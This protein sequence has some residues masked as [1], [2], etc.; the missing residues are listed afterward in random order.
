MPTIRTT[1]WC[2]EAIAILGRDGDSQARNTS[3]K[4]AGNATDPQRLAAI[5]SLKPELHPAERDGL[6][7]LLPSALP[8][9]R[10]AILKKLANCVDP[11]LPDLFL[12]LL[13]E[14]D[15]AQWGPAIKVLA[16]NATPK[17]V[18]ALLALLR[19][20]LAPGDPEKII[21]LNVFPMCTWDTMP[22]SMEDAVSPVEQCAIAL[23]QIGDPAVDPLMQMLHDPDP[24][25]RAAAAALL[26]LQPAARAVAPLTRALTD[27]DPSVREFA[28]YALRMR[29]DVDSLPALVAAVHDPETRVRVA[30]ALALA[31]T[32]DQR[33][34]P[35]LIALLADHEAD[36]QLA[37]A[38][39]LHDVP[40]A[41]SVPAL[42]DCLNGT[43]NAQLR[44]AVLRALRAI[45]DPRANEA[46][47]AALNDP[48]DSVRIQAIAV[49][50]ACRDRRA[51]A[52]LCKLLTNAP[53]QQVAG[54]R[55]D[56]EEM[57]DDVSHAIGSLRGVYQ[58]KHTAQV[59]D[60]L[61]ELDGMSNLLTA[62]QRAYGQGKNPL[63]AGSVYGG[64]LKTLD[65]LGDQA[66]LPT[67][68][69]EARRVSNNGR[70][71]LWRA[72]THC[73][74]AAPAL[75]QQFTALL[76]GDT[77]PFAFHP[78][79]RDAFN[80][81]KTALSITDGMLV[82]LQNHDALIRTTAAEY[83][84]DEAA[85]CYDLQDPAC[86]RLREGAGEPRAIDALLALMD[87]HDTY[88]RTN[89]MLALGLMHTPRATP[90]LLTALFH[91]AD[92]QD[93]ESSQIAL[94]TMSDPAMLPTLLEKLR[95]PDV[96]SRLAA[97]DVLA[98]RQDTRI[99]DALAACLTDKD[100]RVRQR[101]AMVPALQGNG[102]ALDVLISAVQALHGQQKADSD[103][104]LMPYVL[105][106][107]N[108]QRALDAGFAWL[109]GA[110][111]DERGLLPL[112]WYDPSPRVTDYLAQHLQALDPIGQRVLNALPLMLHVQDMQLASMHLG[113]LSPLIMHPEIL[114]ARLRDPRIFAALLAATQQAPSVTEDRSPEHHHTS[115]ALNIN[116]PADR[117]LLALGSAGPY[118]VP[119]LTAKL[120][121]GSLHARQL[122]ARA[123]GESKDPRAVTP[124]LATLRE[125]TGDAQQTAAD[126]LTAITG[127]HFGV[128]ADKWQMWQEKDA[129]GQH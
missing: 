121:T 85:G 120:E 84:L 99:L 60:D 39:G 56:M 61:L 107:T 80:D 36:V 14:H 117:A 47:L 15:K 81:P 68:L 115:G 17:A 92:A 78:W 90:A 102:D 51:V 86:R 16:Y 44:A 97:I 48:D 72:M 59:F 29:G 109:T 74:L 65:H 4:I 77:R 55:G 103:D 18:P 82:A 31:A 73:G 49:L 2:K 35:A 118:A 122:A 32:G 110:S 58:A 33:A 9:V 83:F 52:P 71:Q 37:A 21:Q 98:C 104:V 101:A 100:A 22:F 50:D 42:L 79:Q 88:V 113:L 53:D 63:E 5:E 57:Q 116:F 8:Q 45:G 123:L 30:V 3:L 114:R 125:F 105:L 76:T 69:A 46:A 24:L 34:L 6:L 94:C 12:P 66:A 23:R 13:Q 67:L 124:L 126:A 38:W 108:N 64:A 25:Q 19:A 54:W 89:A 7:A 129:T 1:R 87:D 70:V 26:S 75:Q 28:A 41:A 20:Q 27:A 119:L 112:L 43:K 128:N 111:D 127:Q 96:R 91:G 106:A 95:A 11:R 40:A 93:R 10:Q 62:T